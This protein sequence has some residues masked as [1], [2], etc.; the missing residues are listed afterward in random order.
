M[1]YSVHARGEDFER[2]QRLEE[3]RGCDLAVLKA[4]Q[5]TFKD[6]LFEL[7]ASGPSL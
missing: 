4:S 7:A 2:R 3:G 6:V 1:C 5:E